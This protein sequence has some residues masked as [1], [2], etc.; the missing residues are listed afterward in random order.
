MGPGDDSRQAASLR[1]AL[2][3]HLLAEGTL[4]EERVAAAFQAV[5]RH[6][7]VPQAPLDVAYADDVVLMKRDETGAVI[8]SVS[9]PSIMALMLEQA[10]IRPGDHV[11]EIG[12]GG[13][14]AALLRELAGPEGAVTTVDIDPEVTDRARS[15]LDEA[16]YGDV[17]V[18]RADGA[19]GDPAG[20]PYDRI[21]VTVTA[22][23]IA[24]VW[25]R[26]LRPDGRIVVPLRLRAQTRSIA[27]DRVGAHLESRSTTLCGFVSMQG[28]GAHYERTSPFGETGLTYDEDQEHE[29]RPPEEVLKLPPRRMPSGV[30]VGREEPLLDLY[31]W[32]ASTMPGYCVMTGGEWSWVAAATT[33]DSLVYLTTR[34][35]PGD[36]QLELVCVG[37]GAGAGRLA[38]QMLAQVRLW[39]RRLRHGPGP[40]FQVHAVGAVLPPGFHV[41]RRDSCLTVTWAE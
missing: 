36:L 13:Y 9:Q 27:F 37:H 17:R 38:D 2:I 4:H 10:A 40:A 5:P 31:L 35:R 32:L 20:A 15:S 24:S 23:D 19:Y 33:A 14:N 28:A 8:S 1:A 7:F 21:V 30:H 29:P 26:Q 11:L 18:V 41:A 16:G 25:L 6:L 22:W 34:G 39:D 3:R 12:S